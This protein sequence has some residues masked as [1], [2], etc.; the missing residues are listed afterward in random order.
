MW[1]PS[2]ELVEN[3]GDDTAYRIAEAS[4]R[5]AL[6]T[7]LKKRAHCQT[8]DPKAEPRLGRATLSG[9]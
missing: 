5:R 6:R 8:P 4:K 2:T 9:M 7:L 3:S 1:Q